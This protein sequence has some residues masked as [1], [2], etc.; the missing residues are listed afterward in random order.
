MIR[1]SWFLQNWNLVWSPIHYYFKSCSQMLWEFQ[2]I[3][4]A[5][6]SELSKGFMKQAEFGQN[7]SYQNAEKGTGP[8]KILIIN[9]RCPASQLARRNQA[10]EAEKVQEWY[11]S[12]TPF[13]IF[14]E[15]PEPYLMN[16]LGNSH[17]YTQVCRDSHWNKRMPP[18]VAPAVAPALHTQ[19]LLNLQC[20]P[21]SKH[22]PS[23]TLSSRKNLFLT[24]NLL[25]QKNREYDRKGCMQKSNK[26]YKYDLG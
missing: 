19:V 14:Q 8:A 6:W 1:P 5:G 15:T 10:S 21:S 4:K 9:G 18:A 26:K 20:Q 3:H 25:I 13:G 7:S 24:N 16:L 2:T 17:C 22:L 23:L 11:S 12:G